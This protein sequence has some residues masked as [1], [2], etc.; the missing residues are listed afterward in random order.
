MIETL[1]FLVGAV[2]AFVALWKTDDT[3][4]QIAVP[5][6]LGVALFL[7]V[8]EPWRL[9]S[10]LGLL[11]GLPAYVVFFLYQRGQ[12]V[13]M[14]DYT[15]V[16][17]PAP[18]TPSEGPVGSTRKAMH[19]TPSTPDGPYYIPG[20]PHKQLLAADGTAGEPMRFVGHVRTRGGEPIRGAAIEIWHADGNGDYDNEHYNCRGH[21]YTDEAG[22]FAF[23]T[24]RPFGYGRRSWS[25]AGVVD[26][27]SAHLHVKIRRDG[28][29][30]T[31][32]LWFPDDDERNPTD[33]AYAR[34]QETNV[35]ALDREAGRLVA[36][37]DFVL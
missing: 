28:E 30:F 11:A 8:P 33:V 20:T 26:Y 18:A 34:F 25:M 14:P 16:D 4:A 17:A 37:F 23:E 9:A 27:R 12:R 29:T 31:S 22:A 36:R 19:R 35:L 3:N 15:A 6:I 2:V 32:Q 7:L 10:G 5:P 24:V 1:C 21:Q 13:P